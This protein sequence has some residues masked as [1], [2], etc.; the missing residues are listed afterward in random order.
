MQF[1]I[2]KTEGKV[3]VYKRGDVCEY[4]ELPDGK[5]LYETPEDGDWWEWCDARS[6]WRDDRRIRIC[7][8]V[9]TYSAPYADD[10]KKVAQGLMDR[11]REEGAELGWGELTIDH[12]GMSHTFRRSAAWKD[13]PIY[14]TFAQSTKWTNGEDGPLGGR[15]LRARDNLVQLWGMADAAHE[16]GLDIVFDAQFTIHLFGVRRMW[17]TSFDN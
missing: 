8:P 7:E 17:R 4:G 10:L 14:Y 9:G 6:D 15:A 12:S 16:L 13:E 5:P 2:Y 3:L 11:Y 1:D